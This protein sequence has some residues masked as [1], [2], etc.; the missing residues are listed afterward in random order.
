MAVVPRKRKRGVVYGVLTSWGGGEHWE[1]VG[2]SKREAEQRDRQRKA[3]VKA[4]TFRPGELTDAASVKSSAERWLEKRRNRTAD[5]DRA[6]IARHVLTVNSFA[7]LRM[8]DVRPRD[9]LK[10][11]EGLGKGSLSPKSVSLVMGLVRVMF[12]D[13]VIDDVLPTSPYVVPRGTLKRSGEKRQPYTAAEAVALMA[14]PVGERERIWN[15]IAFYT[16]ARC[17]EVCG[18]RWGDWDELPVPLGALSVERQYAGQ[19]L[20]T[21]RPRVVPVHHRLAQLLAAWRDRWSLYFLRRP[22]SNDLICPRMMGTDIEPLTKNAAYKAWIRSCLAAG[23]TNRSIHSTR[24]TFITLAR[25]GG[26]DKEAVE[27][28]THN[29]KGTIVDRYTTRDW[30]QLCDVVLALSFDGPLDAS[31]SS[32]GIHGSRAWTRTSERRRNRE[33]LATNREGE[34]SQ[35]AP[36]SPADLD[37]AAAFDARQAADD[38]DYLEWLAT[39]AEHSSRAAAF[40]EM[41]SR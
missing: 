11:I 23:V 24:H 19:V 5:N 6:L 2:A 33:K 32:G 7:S 34:S 13:A 20:K 8:A 36:I 10:L 21:E 22:G 27:L 29:P 40:A 38:P 3:E 4:G 14:E 37:S 31:P 18:L 35:G 41:G 15:A 26:A 30:A 17:G 16:G 12:R 28:V 39:L 25:R 9:V 1:L